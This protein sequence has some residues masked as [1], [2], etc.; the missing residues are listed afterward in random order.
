M[1]GFELNKIA[2][3]VLS[4][5]LVISGGSVV[6]DML[7]DKPK[8]EKP[9]WALPVTQLEPAS[10][11]GP[12]PA[13]FDP[14]QVVAMLPQADPDNGRDVFRRCL[15]CHTAEK[16]GPHRIGPNLWGV[17]D[18]AKAAQPGF[19]YSEALKSSPGNW[20]FVDLAKYLH[21]PK[22]EIPGTKMMFAGIKD[23]AELADLL[24]YLRSLSDSPSPLPD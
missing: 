7:W 23:K 15:Q 9:G 20:T 1:D 12:A 14:T 11:A 19:P 4:A 10:R 6:R 5:L 3:A 2:G 18:R 22:A 21:D 13:P 8:P 24:A 17:V 16:D